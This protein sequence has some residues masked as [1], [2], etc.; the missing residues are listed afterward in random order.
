MVFFEADKNTVKL[1]RVVF[2]P[3]GECNKC[4]RTVFQK[5][6]DLTKKIKGRNNMRIQLPIIKPDNKIGKHIKQCHSFHYHFLNK[7]VIYV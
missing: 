3:Y 5:L 4:H 1:N 6:Y 7:N 2:T